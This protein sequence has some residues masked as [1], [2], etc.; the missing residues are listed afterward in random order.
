M[1]PWTP[2]GARN[3]T[4]EIE[5]KELKGLHNNDDIKF[6]IMATTHS[7]PLSQPREDNQRSDEIESQ[8]GMEMKSVHSCWCGNVAW[9]RCHISTLVYSD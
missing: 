5:V 4:C 6:D 2:V 7:G 8:K 3:D 1:T 9:V